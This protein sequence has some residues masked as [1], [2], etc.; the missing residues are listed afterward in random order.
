MAHTGSV[1]DQLKPGMFDSGMGDIVPSLRQAHD[2]AFLPQITDGRVELTREQMAGNGAM[3]IP[4]LGNDETVKVPLEMCGSTP[5]H[6]GRMAT[7]LGSTFSQASELS[8]TMQL[9]LAE[10]TAELEVTTTA[11]V[12]I[13][14]DHMRHVFEP[15]ELNLPRV[16]FISRPM[17]VVH[18]GIKNYTADERGAAL[19][20]EYVHIH[21]IEQEVQ[22]WPAGQ[23]FQHHSH[24]ELRAYHVGSRILRHLG[25]GD[26]SSKM[27]AITHRIE[28]MRAECAEPGKPF[29]PNKQIMPILLAMGVYPGGIKRTPVAQP[30]TDQLAAAPSGR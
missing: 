22:P 11:A 4:L 5:R 17:L 20:H 13:V 24:L 9:K 30:R 19:I 1:L 21:D 23:E 6:I 10:E 18:P 27:A 12:P 2:D 29:E 8:R 14:T 28:D 16:E 15:S 7:M 3:V 25:V 26:E